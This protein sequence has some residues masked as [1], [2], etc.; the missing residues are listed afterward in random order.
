MSRR[1][2]AGLTTTHFVFPSLGKRLSEAK[3]AVESWSRCFSGFSELDGGEGWY[4]DDHG[5]GGLAV[6]P[7]IE[8]DN[9]N[10]VDFVESEQRCVF[11][12]VSVRFFAK[13]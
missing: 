8:V 9:A 5:F 10:S 6:S 1:E 4:A 2:D 12:L 13:R 3:P 11:P 7:E